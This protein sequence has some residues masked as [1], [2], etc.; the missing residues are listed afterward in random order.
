MVLEISPRRHL[1]T[2]IVGYPD[3]KLPTNPSGFRRE[4]EC[5]IFPLDRK[6]IMTLSKL[7]LERI[8]DA[9]VKNERL[10]IQFV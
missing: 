1:P 2:E 4:A 6:K 5:P 7:G 9:E 8:P 10:P 3:E